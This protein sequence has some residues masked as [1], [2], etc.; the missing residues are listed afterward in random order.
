MQWKVGDTLTFEIVRNEKT[1]K[2]EG[3]AI[4]PKTEQKSLVIEELP[5]D[6]P[7]TKLRKAWLKD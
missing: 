1:I 7:K 2:L 6:N 5:A 4:A 3:K